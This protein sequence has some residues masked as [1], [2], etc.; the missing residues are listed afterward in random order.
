[1]S[2]Y[3]EARNSELSIMVEYVCVI[4][5]YGIERLQSLMHIAG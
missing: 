3:E 4:Y 1:M 5:K 2:I